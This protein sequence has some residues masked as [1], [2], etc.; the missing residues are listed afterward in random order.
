MMVVGGFLKLSQKGLYLAC[1][2]RVCYD[3]QTLN[4]FE[5]KDYSVLG[6]D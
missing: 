6:S 1:I 5:S 4:T 2:G 3:C